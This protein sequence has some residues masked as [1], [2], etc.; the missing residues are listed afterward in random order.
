MR[1]QMMTTLCLVLLPGVAL[2]TET[3]GQAIERQAIEYRREH[4]QHGRV[5]IAVRKAVAPSVR[6]ARLTMVAM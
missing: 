1:K 6:R 4:L 2:Q 5:E 3:P